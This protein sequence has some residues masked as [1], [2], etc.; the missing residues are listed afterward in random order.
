M[1]HCLR[2]AEIV[3][4]I[5]FHLDP[6]V[7]RNARLGVSRS[8]GRL[9][10]LAVLARTSKT[11]Q[12]PALDLLWNSAALVDLL[13]GCMPSDLWAID[14]GPSS[15]YVWRNE[16]KIRLCR[17]IRPSDWHRVC[18]YA[19]RVRILTSGPFSS[20][21]ARVFQAL[22]VSLPEML[23]P[24][25]QNL[26]WGHTGDDFFYIRL[27][28]HPTITR[29]SFSLSSDSATSFLS[30]LA[31]KCP[32]LTKVDIESHYHDY[33]S[34][35]ISDFVGGL[36]RV[37]ELSVYSLE[38][39][40][41][42]HLS[43]SP[44]LK[45][46]TLHILPV[47]TSPPC[48]QTPTFPALREL[49][50][51]YPEIEPTVQFLGLCRAV[52]LKSFTVCLTEF[53]T[54]SETHDLLA[55][56]SAGVNPSTLDFLHVDNECDHSNETDTS[57]YL[58]RPHSLQ[59]L[60][61]FTHLAMLSITSPL[62]FDLGDED[63]AAFARAWPRLV[64][65]E[66]GVRFS[67]HDP[68]TTLLCLN[69]LAQHCRRLV[70]LTIALDATNV[71]TPE[72]DLSTRLPGY[73]LEY[74]HVAHSPISSPIAVARFLSGV[75]PKLTTLTTIRELHNNLDEEELQEHGEVIR[76]HNKWKQVLELLPHLSAIREEGRVLGRLGV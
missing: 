45:S 65:L 73:S 55:A 27:F 12:E 3:A 34:R 63:V 36:Q 35:A 68:R 41:L 52:P 44:A 72:I 38:Q 61:P 76:R 75:F 62:G 10:N 71:P 25:L 18:L 30:F 22:S 39:D 60:F 7:S 8:S 67:M 47:W 13:V 9:R 29:I 2:V 31:Q 43:H 48:L 14:I 21:L 66:L 6:R 15:T 74:L 19:R 4:M 37:K 23:F 20:S 28:L 17:P 57:L 24:N 26:T 5:C 58:I 33:D 1:H 40:I 59:A 51:T 46:L 53:V 32:E 69:S 49:S 11:F 16:K 42:E 64:T 70:R 56:I 54:A 50:L